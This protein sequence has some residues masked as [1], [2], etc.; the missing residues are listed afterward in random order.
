MY[1]QNISMHLN[2]ILLDNSKKIFSKNINNYKIYNYNKYYVNINNVNTLG[3]F[4]SVIFNNNKCVCMSPC[5]SYELNYFLKH[6][7]KYHI[8]EFVEGIMIN[9]FFYNN[10]WHIASYNLL[11]NIDTRK[12]FFEHFN[13]NNFKKMNKQYSY[14]FVFQHQS[15]AIINN[16]V[17]KIYLIDIFDPVKCCSVKDDNV[18][19]V[20]LDGILFPKK[21]ELPLQDA[22]KKY[23]SVDSDYTF[24]GLVLVNNNKRAKIRNSAFEYYKYIHNN[25]SLLIIFDFCYMFKNKLLQN[26]KLKYDINTLNIIKKMY[27]NL[28]YSIY[29]S[30]RNIYIRKTD[31]INNYLN[32]KKRILLDLHKKY[33]DILMPNGKFITKKYVINYINDMSSYDLFILISG[34]KDF[35]KRLN[36]LRI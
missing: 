1:K 25:N 31:S 6:N 14:S 23:C 34:I 33:I 9:C 12:I 13:S 22:L 10:E 32:I 18:L 24:K 11:D 19:N 8:E 5:K 30:Y 20:S 4:R 7:S 35:Y 36:E 17:T 16:K 29:I 3:L 27:Y 15:F 2:N 21:I 28:T 26:Y